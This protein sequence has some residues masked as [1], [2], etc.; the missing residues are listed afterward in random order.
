MLQPPAHDLSIAGNLMHPYPPAVQRALHLLADAGESA[1]VV[2]GAARDLLMGRA[3][4][5]Y[6]IVIAG[7]GLA[8][9]R[10]LANTLGGVFVA[11]DEVRRVGRVVVQEGD[12]PLWMD[13]AQF[14]DGAASLDDDL[15]RRD[16]TVNAIA[17]DADGGV[18]DPTGGVADIAAK[19]LRLTHPQSLDD[20]PLRLLRGVRLQGSHGFALLP[21]TLQAMRAAAPI[22]GR[23]AM[24]RVREEWFGLLRPPDAAARVDLLASVGVLEAILPELVACRGVTQSPPHSHDVYGHH[25]LVLAAIEP[26]IAWSMG[27][28]APLDVLWD[29]ALAP[30]RADIA[31]Y[32]S[33]EVAHDLPRALLLKQVALIHD[34]GKVATRSVGEDGRIHFYEHERVG[35]AMVEP[36]GRRLTLPVR[37]IEAAERMI[38][39]HMRP[40][41]LAMQPPPSHRAIYRFFRDTRDEGVAVALHSIADQR[42]KALAGDRAEVLAVAAQLVRAYVEAPERYVTVRPLLDGNALMALTGQRGP[43]IGEMLAFLREQQAMGTVTTREAAEQAIRGW[44]PRAT[45]KR[46]RGND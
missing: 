39:A 34:M 41:H 35:A 46:T 2:G 8:W 10:L 4:K 31:R 1:W 3:V 36:L 40:L 18:I 43:V 24:E 21:D 45:D 25:L 11:L 23:V 44:N 27:A 19:Q 33:E 9:A 28:E 26:I 5:D 16:F 42:G 7:D 22:L 6:D 20:D 32:L 38:A 15:R 37:A 30:Y 14:R 29:E 12:A 17:L 13:I